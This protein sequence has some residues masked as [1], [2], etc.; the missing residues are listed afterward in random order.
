MSYWNAKYTNNWTWKLWS[1]VR[2]ASTGSKI[3]GASMWMM[4]IIFTVQEENGKKVLTD[5]HKL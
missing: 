2:I 3:H 4:M 1:D 5:E